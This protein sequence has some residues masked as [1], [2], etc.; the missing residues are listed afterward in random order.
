MIGAQPLMKGG[1]ISGT[2][3]HF[4]R[5]GA[6]LGGQWQDWSLAHSPCVEELKLAEGK[7]TSP[8]ALSLC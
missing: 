5:A 2:S 1:L 6:R 3:H 4:M 7:A 8:C